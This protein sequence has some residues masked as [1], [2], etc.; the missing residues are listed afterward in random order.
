[1]VNVS[2]V[3]LTAGHPMQEL[4]FDRESAI[5]GTG[6]GPWLKTKGVDLTLTGAGQKLGLAEV[7]GRVV[8]NRCRSTLAGIKERFGYPYP[9]KW[10]PRL[11]ADVVC[12][13]NRTARRGESLSPS[14]K[15]FGVSSAMD[16]LRDMRASIG[17]VLLFKRPKRTA[18]L[19][20]L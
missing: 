15:F 1:M 13:L 17:E 16:L 19:P 10:I 4:R 3:C 7:S 5:A 11:V 14:Q 18:S 20:I 6:I 8:K 2:S 9:T 12:V